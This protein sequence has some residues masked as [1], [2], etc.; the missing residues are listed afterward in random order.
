MPGIPN[1]ASYLVSGVT[2]SSAVGQDLDLE[3]YLHS[4][5]RESFLLDAGQNEDEEAIPGMR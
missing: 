1:K 3:S 5:I 4:K 2:A